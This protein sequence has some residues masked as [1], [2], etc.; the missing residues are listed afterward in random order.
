M[1]FDFK[2]TLKS[3][4]D[5][6]PSQLFQN[7]HLNILIS[8]LPSLPLCVIILVQ[9]REMNLIKTHAPYDW[10]IYKYDILSRN[11]LHPYNTLKTMKH[12]YFTYKFTVLFYHY[13][14][15]ASVLCIV[16]LSSRTVMLLITK[17]WNKLRM[18]AL[19]SAKY[20]VFIFYPSISYLLQRPTY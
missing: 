4:I 5:L 3:R 20:G 7:A 1:A 10:C 14:N 19:L 12:Q 13:Q 17:R 15:I 6:S 18:C 16:P 8:K 9:N 2:I 11:F